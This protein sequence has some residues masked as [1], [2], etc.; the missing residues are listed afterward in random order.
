M[1][2]FLLIFVLVAVGNC[3]SLLEN[4]GIVDIGRKSS[5]TEIEVPKTLISVDSTLNIVP[6]KTIYTDRLQSDLFTCENDFLGTATCP[7]VKSDC[8]TNEQYYDGFSTKHPIEK[9]YQSICP[10]G[11][12]KSN[13][14]CYV[15]EN[16]DGIKDSYRRYALEVI[17]HGVIHTGNWHPVVPVPPPNSQTNR[18]DYEAAKGTYN[19]SVPK[20]SYSK[21]SIISE[22]ARRGCHHFIQANIDLNGVRKITKAVE[23]VNQ[24]NGYWT[25]ATAETFNSTDS[26]T[27]SYNNLFV[28]RS[29]TTQVTSSSRRPVIK[30]TTRICKIGKMRLI[31]GVTMCFEDCPSGYTS[32]ENE[33]CKKDTECPIDAIKQS[34]GTCKMNYD[35]Y[36]YHCED[37]NNRYENPW[38]VINPGND[39]GST[40]CTNVP[41]PPTNNCARL[42]YICPSDPDA[43]CGKTA[44]AAPDCKAGFTW[45]LGRCERDEKYCGTSTYNSAK[46]VCED[47][48]IISKECVN[49]TD[50]YNE[51]NNR[52]ESGNLVCP[53]GLYDSFLGKCTNLKKRSCENSGF[54]YVLLTDSC[55]N[56]IAP[57]CE[58]S[59]YIY[60]TEKEIC[61]APIDICPA[62]EEYDE[63]SS[64]CRRSLCNIEGTTDN[65]SRCET[66]NQC[67]GTLT[68]AG[69]C[70]PSALQ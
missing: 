5:P 1:K 36:S 17:S 9:N 66:I 39:C 30:A 8:P 29:M 54:T 25:F 37:N 45:N 12:I 35:W 15:D 47:T 42:D 52:C 26:L 58:D 56:P 22:T 48:A 63:I 64:R 6:N 7:E 10:A 50:V 18:P 49:P 44:S 32:S 38:V 13:D 21:V 24:C 68:S 40:S 2:K 69:A 61:I 20:N 14:R 62:N 59:N 51:V 65:N 23:Y 3:G 43:L 31:D 46:E 34:D 53:D 57:T 67:N 70:I 41:T 4:R 55:I 60:D 33:F 19:I 28:Y 16:R 11:T 27:I